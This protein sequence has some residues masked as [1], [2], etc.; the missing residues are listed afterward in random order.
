[1]NLQQSTL[2]QKNQTV[3]PS[4]VRRTLN[5]QAGDKITWRVARHG[6]SVSAIAEPMPK[7]WTGYM[8]GLGKDMW[9]DVD[10]DEYVEQLRK[11]WDSNL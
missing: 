2:S 9:K 10:I 8:A 1:M 3:I 11:E 6:N 4:A 7:N 5:L